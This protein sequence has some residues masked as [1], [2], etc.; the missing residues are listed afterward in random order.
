VA[1]G[2]V[3]HRKDWMEE[4][5]RVAA[6]FD[7]DF[8][9]WGGDLAYADGREDR[10][11]NWIEWFDALKSTLV[12]GDGRVIP[13]VVAIGNHE[14]RGGYY[15]R[16]E[17]YQ[18][19]AETR[20]Q[21]APYFYRLFAM[22][23]QPGYNAL[24]FG[25]Y[26]S[27][28]LLDTNHT[29]PISGEQT[30]WL[31]QTLAERK[32]VPHIFPLYHVTAYPSHRSFED[33]TSRDIREH[34]APLFEKFNVRVAFENHDHTYKRTIPIREGKPHPQ[35][36]VYIGD[37]CWGVAPRKIHDPAETWYLETAHSA[38]HVIV[39]TLHR[40]HQHF[41]VVNTDGEIIDEFPASAQR[42]AWNG[43]GIS[44]ELSP[45]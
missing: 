16:N 21:M 26:L 13:V 10:L 8:I 15:F 35:G 9:I 28:L 24:D 18:Q 25:D 7:P 37:G 41:L 6:H 14:V 43:M 40:T 3:R 32:D 12:A 11:D 39:V 30:E 42:A 20:E 17:E 5:N 2:D 33:R 19:D 44:A 31:A 38:R 23:G 36:I 1:G 27:I 34:W 4:G 29:N 45:K 22:P